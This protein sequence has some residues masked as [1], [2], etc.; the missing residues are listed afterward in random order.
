MSSIVYLD[1]MPVPF[2]TGLAVSLQLP[3]ERNFLIIGAIV[4]SGVLGVIALVCISYGRLT[5]KLILKT[6]IAV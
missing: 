5:S 3:L 2:L 1:A 6:R 4:T